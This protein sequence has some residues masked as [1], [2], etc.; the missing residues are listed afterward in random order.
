MITD[1]A[2]FQPSEDKVLFMNVDHSLWRKGV[3]NF[4]HSKVPATG[5]FTRLRPSK[6]RTWI[7]NT[8]METPLGLSDLGF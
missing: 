6:R 1:P 5:I 4:F 7:A 3:N 8:G 2:L